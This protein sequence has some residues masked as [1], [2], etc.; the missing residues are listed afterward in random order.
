VKGQR[1][2]DNGHFGN[3]GHLK[4]T[5]SLPATR[6][7]KAQ[8]SSEPPFTASLTNLVTGFIIVPKAIHRVILINTAFPFPQTPDLPVGFIT[9]QV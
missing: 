5:E 7:Q 3:E 1:D 8:P 4:V 2:M 9:V 6:Q